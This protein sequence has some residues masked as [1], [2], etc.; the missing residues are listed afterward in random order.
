[1][2]K[3]GKRNPYEPLTPQEIAK[4][5]KEKKDIQ[6]KI[7]SVAKLASE[8]LADPKFIKY[9]EDFEVLRRD[10]FELVKTPIDPDPIKDA[11][12]L[13]SCINSIIFLDMLLEKPKADLKKGI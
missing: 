10:V 11:H 1:M 6:A 2:G 7:K 9:A 13:R 4:K 8:C 12:Y 3:V 5:E